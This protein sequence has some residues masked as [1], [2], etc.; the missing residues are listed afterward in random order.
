MLSRLHRLPGCMPPRCGPSRP[1][2][3]V[4]ALLPLATGSSTVRWG[5]SS[6]LAS[7]ISPITFSLSLEHYFWGQ[8]CRRSSLI[9]RRK[10]SRQ[11]LVRPVRPVCPEL[12]SAL[13]QE[14][15]TG[16][17]SG[18][19][20]LEEIEILFSRNSPKPWKTKVGQSKLQEEIDNAVRAQSRGL[21]MSEYNEEKKKMMQ[22]GGLGNGNE[23]AGQQEVEHM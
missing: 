10:S 15:D 8:P 16:N 6:H 20:T 21:S 23:K 14:T 13:K 11:S 9:Q 4:W 17:H 3:L 1:E 12:P 7:E 2:L 5:S 18:G 22:A 19:K